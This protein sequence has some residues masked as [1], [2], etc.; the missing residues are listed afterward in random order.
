M[1]PAQ[2]FTGLTN[3]I[4]SPEIRS[5]NELKGKVVLIDF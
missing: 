4:N 1:Y 3:W 2:K 5:M